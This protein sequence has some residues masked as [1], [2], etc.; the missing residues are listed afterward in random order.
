MGLGY[1][2]TRNSNGKLEP[3][4]DPNQQTIKLEVVIIFIILYLN[5]LVRHVCLANA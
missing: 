3:L 1:W 2:M 4:V 5:E